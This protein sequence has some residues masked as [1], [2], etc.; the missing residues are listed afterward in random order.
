MESH[1]EKQHNMIK[2]SKIESAKDQAVAATKAI[3]DRRRSCS[4][5]QALHLSPALVLV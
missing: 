2:M 5:L 4:V 1:E 3:K